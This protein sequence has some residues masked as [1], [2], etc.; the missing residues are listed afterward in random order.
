MNWSIVTRHGKE[1]MI[2]RR[3]MLT[4]EEVRPYL[5]NERKSTAKLDYKY[6]YIS[7]YSAD[8]DDSVRK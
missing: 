5:E 4:K 3:R 8:V 7:G 1:F 6:M 2:S